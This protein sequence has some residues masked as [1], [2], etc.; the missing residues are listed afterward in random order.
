M[1][2][3]CAVSAATA[4]S[5]L[6]FSGDAAL[7]QFENELTCVREFFLF[8]LFFFYDDSAGRRDDLI[9][10]LRLTRHLWY[11]IMARALSIF[12]RGSTR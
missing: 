1:S 12:L 10:A 7:P 3:I 11:S 6:S 8:F 5:C 2:W 4:A 9:H